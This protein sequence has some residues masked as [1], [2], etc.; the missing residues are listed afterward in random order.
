MKHFLIFV[1]L[2]CGHLSAAVL[3]P[4][5]NKETP[6]PPVIDPPVINHNQ[7][8][9]GGGFVWAPVQ[10]NGKQY[11]SLEALK[12]FYF[13]NKLEVIE[14]T[15]ILE[16]KIITAEFT[17][18][19]QKARI[20]GINFHLSEPARLKEGV[21]HVSSL[22]V[23]TLIDPV[24]RP[25]FIKNA[26]ATTTVI[27]DAGHGGKDKGS[28]G[29][30]AKHTLAVVKLT[31]EL[32]EKKGYQV[33][34]TRSKDI[35]IPLE[36]RLK[37]INATGNAVVVSLHFNSGKKEAAGFETYVMS[38]RQPN[39]FNM[40]SVALATAVHTRS[41]IYLNNAKHGNDFK[42]EDRGIRRAKFRLLKDSKHP[43]ILVEAGFLTNKKEAEK[44]SSIDYQK[45]LASAIAR[46]IDVYNASIGRKKR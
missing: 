41:L 35:G 20:N 32:L 18:N 3:L 45:T 1:T 33:I 25:S 12:A 34:L 46:G 8:R 40:A 38:A 31:K 4:L 30:E 42:I 44:I 7:Q 28:A 24:L 36:A 13:F 6:Q 14:K 5:D 21:A 29:K 37:Q 2:F 9:E 22:D 26:H 39:P 43:T 17:I 16:N 27:L 19:S 23:M 11:L 15:V 10:I